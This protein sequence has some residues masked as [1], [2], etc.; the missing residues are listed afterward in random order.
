MRACRCRWARLPHPRGRRCRNGFDFETDGIT[1]GADRAIGDNLIVGIAG[2]LAA[3]DSTLDANGASRLQA[4]QRSLAL[5]GLWRAGEHLFVDAVA[6]TGQLDFDLQRWSTEADA[7]GTA[8]R[9]GDQQFASLS[10]GYAHQGASMNLT[11]YGRLDASRTTLDAYREHGLALYDLAYREQVVDS[12][13]AAI[14][15]EGQWQLGE[16]GRVRPFWSVEYRQALEDKGD[17]A[18]NYVLMPAATD[19]RL[20]M[21]SYNDN[22][23]SLSAGLDVTLRRGWLLS[24]LLGHEQARNASEA[25]RIGLRLSYGAQPTAVD[26]VVVPDDGSLSAVPEGEC[27]I[28]RC[29]KAGTR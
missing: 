27:R 26:P 17:A 3:N 8:T 22:A 28:A 1:L 16:A 20:R 4:D 5:Y 9:D 11:G 2:S 18:I 24:L 21:S 12:R 13:T 6:G 15:L 25:S 10:M 29:R 7:L 23:L 14:G 19:Y